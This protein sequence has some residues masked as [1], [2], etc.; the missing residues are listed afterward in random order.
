[1]CTYLLL[2]GRHHRWDGGQAGWTG[3][4][5]RGQEKGGRHGHG[6]GRLP[7]TVV[8]DS[9]VDIRAQRTLKRDSATVASFISV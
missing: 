5:G 2:C 6:W 8:P 1:M 7:T 9:E 4:D 3:G